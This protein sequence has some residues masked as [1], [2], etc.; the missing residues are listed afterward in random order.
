MVATMQKPVLQAILLADNVYQDMS[1]KHIICGVFSSL[2]IVKPSPDKDKKTPK[3][4]ADY[5]M[6]GSPWVYASLT[7]IR[8][9]TE[10]E[11]RY[12]HLET[13]RVLFALNAN[14]QCSD[15]LRTVEFAVPLPP[16]PRKL[17]T[18]ALELVAGGELLG[19]HRVIVEEVGSND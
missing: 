8:S 9:E 15:P 18:H 10:L 6:V 4:P 7:E 2:R 3:R 5:Q 13:D 11:I 16:L 1:G 14:V 12:V 17:G 19:A